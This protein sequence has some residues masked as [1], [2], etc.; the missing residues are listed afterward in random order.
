MSYWVDRTCKVLPTRTLHGTH[1]VEANS[2]YVVLSLGYIDFLCPLINCQYIKYQR[3]VCND[4]R[5]LLFPEG[6]L[7]TLYNGLIVLLCGQI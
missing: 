1:L 7:S 6:I 3:F 5:L 4:C 2:T